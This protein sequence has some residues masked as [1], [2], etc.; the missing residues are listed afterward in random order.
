MKNEKLV[1]ICLTTLNRYD[2]EVIYCMDKQLEYW[3]SFL[4]H[5]NCSYCFNCFNSFLFVLPYSTMTH[6]NFLNISHFI[7]FFQLHFVFSHSLQI[8][9]LK[10]LPCHPRIL[11]PTLLHSNRFKQR[12]SHC[13]NSNAVCDVI[14]GRCNNPKIYCCRI[15]Q[16]F[17][18]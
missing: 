5:W 6:Q 14:Y 1:R 15:Y 16:T 3:S 2:L 18:F 17:L 8:L 13:V 11:C 4:E 10:L 12:L 9:R 7:L